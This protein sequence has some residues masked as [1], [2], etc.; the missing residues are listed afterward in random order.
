MTAQFAIST[1]SRPRNNPLG[2]GSF[3]HRAGADCDGH[4]HAEMD[5]SIPQV[6]G[7]TRFPD[8][9]DAQ[10]GGADHQIGRDAG[11]QQHAGGSAK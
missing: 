4:E 3:Q 2:S 10:H 7:N 11:E 5:E 1:T 8:R 6:L 9:F